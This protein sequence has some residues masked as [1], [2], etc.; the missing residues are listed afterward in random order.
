M[1]KALKIILCVLAALILIVGAYVAY[2]FIAYNR[3]PEV[4]ALEVKG[5]GVGSVQTGRPYK[6]ISFNTG[7]GAYEPD[8]GFFMDGGTQSWAWSKDRLLTNMAAIA[9]FLQ[10]QS[11]DFYCVQEVD[12]NATRTYHVN[13]RE[14]LEK[15]MIG[16]EIVY[17]QNWNS[18]FLFYPLTQPH[19][20]T[21]CGIMTFSRFDI[22]SSIRQS[23]PV[24]NT[25]MKVADLDRCYSASRIPV[26]NGREL[27]LY[28]MHLS[29]Y[30]SDG[31][32][33]NDQLRLLLTDMKGE[34]ERGNYV[35][36]GGD[37]NKDLLGDSSQYFG[38]PGE[39][40][41]WTQPLPEGTFD[42]VPLSLVASSNAPSCRTAD[43]PYN[44]SQFVLTIDG[45][46]VSDNV[47]VLSHEVI[48]TGF[49][50]S[51]HNPVSITF[52]LAE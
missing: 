1:N 10:T 49:A 48:D 4:T 30:T 27:V 51:D 19:G 32:I 25:L 17:A 43:G 34:V 12:E 44:P 26:D 21:R 13:E 50:M 38:V 41:T 42:Q 15:A 24:E 2:V 23:L 36:C 37:F 6:L 16:Y 9:D 40:Y 18:P 22:A 3:L 20:K 5:N 33:A 39:A 14:L 45:F 7:F 29:A 8:Y 46:I 28:N 52:E 35:V 31:A 11:A 47:N